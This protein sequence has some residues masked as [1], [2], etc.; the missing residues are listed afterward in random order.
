[1]Q[2]SARLCA[3]EKWD[4]LRG[5]DGVCPRAALPVVDGM[6]PWNCSCVVLVANLP[7]CG[8]QLGAPEVVLFCN[9][10]PPKGS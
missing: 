4:K 7:P 1:M 2:E 6:D 8:E 9:A 3:S 5:K 10:P